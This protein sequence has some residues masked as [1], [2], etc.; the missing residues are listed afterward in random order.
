MT[1]IA[2]AASKPSGQTIEDGKAAEKEL[3]AMESCQ[4]N[5]SILSMIAD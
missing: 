2:L 3:T 1:K 4:N 5:L